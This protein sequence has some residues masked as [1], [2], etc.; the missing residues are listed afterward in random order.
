[1]Q[2]HRGTLILVLGILSIII[3]CL[4]LGIIAW[5][6][7]NSDLRAMN[8]GR[9]DPAG[10]DLTVGGKICGIIGSILFILGIVAMV[11]FL[12]LGGAAAFL[13]AR[14]VQSQM[15]PEL[16]PPPQQVIPLLIPR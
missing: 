13:S 11:F 2:H 15:P 16:A 12:I 9:M 8:E 10:R 5:V 7:G 6:M 14:D 1:M 4:P 3:T